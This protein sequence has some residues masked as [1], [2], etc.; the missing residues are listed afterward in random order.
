[1]S[2]QYPITY[3]Y[4]IRKP[5]LSRERLIEAKECGFNLIECSYD[6]ETNLKVLRW[7]QELGLKANV[8]D[9][10]MYT[11]LDGKDGW[12]QVM[13]A[14]I[15]DYRDCPAVN[16]FFIRDEPIDVDIPHLA[17][18]VN[19]LHEH[20]PKHGEYINQLPLPAFLPYERYR[21]DIIRAYIAQAHPTILSYDHYN[22]MRREVETLTDLPAAR[23]SDE[24][25]ARNHWEDKVFDAY[26]RPSYYDNLEMIR[27][28]AAAA[29]IPWM[30][31]ILLVE[32]WHYRFPTEGEV[33][34]EAFTALTYGSVGL[35][36]F[37]YWT[38][39]VGHGEPWSYHNGIIL[40]DGT[41][42]EKYEIVKGINAELQTLYAGLLGDVPGV[43][44]GPGALKS[45]AVFH[46]GEEE[47]QMVRPFG[48]YGKV[49]SLG[50]G[51][52]IAGFFE[53][54]RMMVTNKDHDHPAVLTIKADGRLL[55][56]N[57]QTSEWE[58]CD[59]TFAFTPG[60]GELFC[61]V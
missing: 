30:I 7:C 17:R 16:R 2:V 23:L 52:F 38:P 15:S 44:K 5:F 32:H 55:H 37:T 1:M 34:W 8:Q 21:N 42:G 10:R 29:G 45:E 11:V 20:D 6:T 46:V 26:D 36:Y 54:G 39:G 24:N 59:G 13:D 41:R 49:T 57:K 27:D 31:I 53:G 9:P 25:I 43:S 56:L 33:R 48:G 12:E 18:V 35:S 51:R 3:W 19:Y 14:I 60:D 50:G 40:S 47:D 61:V 22:L 58:A 28:E 4:G